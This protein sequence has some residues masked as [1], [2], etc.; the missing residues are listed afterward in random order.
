MA[1]DPTKHA[2]WEIAEE[3]ESRMKTCYQLAEEL[4]LTKEELL[5]H[6][7]YIAKVNYMDVLNRLSDP[8]SQSGA[9]VF[10]DTSAMPLAKPK[11]ERR[12]TIRMLPAG[13]NT[14][15]GADSKTRLSTNDSGE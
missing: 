1:L 13:R 14:L 7:N 2:D 5:P 3:A 10:L 8:P 11:S 4:G 6:G 9:T 15:W 12:Q